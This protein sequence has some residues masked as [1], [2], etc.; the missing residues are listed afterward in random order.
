MA[1]M[2]SSCS[3]IEE[4]ELLMTVPADASLVTISNW[5]TLLKN[6]GCQA[7]Q[8]K[9]T[10]SADLKQL[11][12]SATLPFGEIIGMAQFIN[13]NE[14]VTFKTADQI[15]VATFRITDADGFYESIKKSFPKGKEEKGFICHES[16][17]ATAS[18]FVK[19]SQGWL[20]EGQTTSVKWLSKM[21]NDADHA[22]ISNFQSIKNFLEQEKAL[23]IIV[24]NKMLNIEMLDKDGWVCTSMEIQGANVKINIDLINEDGTSIDIGKTLSTLNPD[25]LRCVPPNSSAIFAIGV[26]S[27][28]EWDNIEATILPLL[29]FR[30]RG[31]F[32]VYKQYIEA[33]DGTI[34]IA[35]SPA[36]SAPGI[37][38]IST[39]TWDFTLLAHMPPNRIYEAI[40]TVVA[41][42]RRSGIKVLQEN[43]MYLL[44]LPEGPLYIGYKY[45]CLALSTRE[46]DEWTPNTTLVNAFA[47][48]K[49]LVALEVPFNSEIMKAFELPCGFNLYAGIDNSGLSLSLR[50]NG[51]NQPILQ[52][53]ISLMTKNLK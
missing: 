17:Q 8:G 51:N 49:A 27:N 15:Q 22:P 44:P 9:V 53:L 23:N 26:S 13:I 34:V 33:I 29:S 43:G 52:T 39:D 40:N 48:R 36:G 31:S 11:F 41:Y 38:N 14:I 20:V 6:A 46:I 19:G 47:G 28:F 45:G 21:L 16:S 10:L 4:K 3:S 1:A 35:A 7:N 12:E 50:A 42:M 18:L 37:A 25:Y 5:D 2:L 30:L 24:S 32:E